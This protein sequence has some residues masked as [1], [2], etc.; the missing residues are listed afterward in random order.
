MN[1]TIQDYLTAIGWMLDKEGVKVTS[2]ANHRMLKE[3]KITL[4]AFQA[5]ARVISE[6]FLKEGE[7]ND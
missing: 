5:A 7:Q 3:G 1:G 4:E 6:R 2:A